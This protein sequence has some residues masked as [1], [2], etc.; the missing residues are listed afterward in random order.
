MIDKIKI[1]KES[2]NNDSTV[3]IELDNALIT[4]DIILNSPILILVQYRNNATCLD[5][6]LSWSI[7]HN[8]LEALEIQSIGASVENMLIEATANGLGSLWVGD[9]MYA[10][11][12]IS[13]AL[14]LKYPLISAVVL[15]H[16]EKKSAK[17]TRKKMKDIVDW[18]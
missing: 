6:G 1:L 15:G 7:M 5:D 8:E 3:R 9:I 14:N 2:N 4:S 18:R 16:S 10:G 17:S 13:T 11:T 12:E